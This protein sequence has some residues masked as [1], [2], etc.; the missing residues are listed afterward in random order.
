M[1]PRSRNHVFEGQLRRQ[2]VEQLAI[3]KAPVGHNGDFHP[4]RQHLPQPAQHL[5][6]IAPLIPLQR[7]GCHRRPQQGRRAPMASHHR[8]HDRVLPV[9]RKARPI[10]RDDHLGAGADDERRPVREKGPRRC[11][12]TTSV[13]AMNG[14]Q[15]AKKG[16]DVEAL[17]CSAADPPASHHAWSTCPWPGPSRAPLHGLPAKRSSAR[18]G[19]RWPTT[20]PV[21][22]AGRL[23]TR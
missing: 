21:W 19:W 2:R 18:P 11:A 22:H 20:A 3:R 15:Y 6:L 4:G 16:P 23:R 17:D 8:Q 1:S 10:Q 9:G 13:R 12:T 14:V 5:V 7:R